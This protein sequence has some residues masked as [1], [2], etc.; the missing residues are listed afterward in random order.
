[1][2]GFKSFDNATITM[3]GIELGGFSGV[4]RAQNQ[5]TAQDLRRR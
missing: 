3:A 4:R 1:M 5:R 2:A